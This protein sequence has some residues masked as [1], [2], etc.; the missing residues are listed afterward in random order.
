MVGESGGVSVGGGGGGGS[1]KI[2]SDGCFVVVASHQKEGREV[3]CDGRGAGG[4][5]P[6]K[7]RVTSA[8]SLWL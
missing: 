5:V 3:T 1:E 2:C 6:R 8:G 7:G 4:C